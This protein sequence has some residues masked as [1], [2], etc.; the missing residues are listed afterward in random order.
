MGETRIEVALPLPVRSTFTYAVEGSQPLPG[1][2]VLVPF[3]QTERIGWVVGPG[4]PESPTRVRP[5]LDR[6]EAD[7]SVP[8]D[9]M[10]LAAWVADYYLAPLGMVL[11]TFLPSVLSDTGRDYLTY[12]GGKGQTLTPRQRKLMEA[13]EGSGHALRVRTLRRELG[14]GSLWPEIRA[15]VAGGVLGHEAIPPREPSVRTQKVVRLREW[16]SDLSARDELFGRARRQREAYETLESAGGAAELSHLVT[17]GGFSRSV[18]QGLEEK[19]VVVLEDSEVYRDP[20]LEDPPPD[21]PPLVPTPDQARV[22]SH[23]VEAL[24]APKPTPVLLHGV[25]GSGKTLVYIEL[26]KEVVREQGRGAIVLVPEIALTP[27][28]VSRF[29]AHFPDDLAVLHSGLSEGERFDAWRRL[30]NG[31]KRIAVGAR[32]AVFAPVQRLGVIVV[33]EEHDASYKQ[34]EGPRY[35]ARDVAVVRTRQTGG[36]CVLGSATPSLESWQ[37]GVLGKYRL[38]TLPQ[39]VGG[40]SL[41]PVRVVDLRT[42]RRREASG[43]RAGA[44]SGVL[45]DDLVEGIRVRLR[46]GE[47]VMLLLNRRGY[48][49]FVQCRECGEVW[50]CIRCSVSLT[51]HRLTGKLL[52]HHCRHEEPSPRRCDRC[53]STDLSFKGLGTEQ[54]ERVVAETFPDARIARMD[55]D[56]TSGK[57]SHHEILGRFGRGEVDILLG[58]QMISKGLDF[59]TVTLVGVVNADIGIH[60]PDFRAS[61]R[62]FQLLSQVAGRTGRGRLGGEVVVQTS[63]PDHFAVRA[64]LNHD[65]PAFA[66]RELAERASPSYPPHVRLANVLVSSP[67]L[68]EA[69]REA[70]AGAAWVRRAVGRA[71]Q[72]IEVVGPAPAPIEQLHGR[73]RWHFLVRSRGAA[74]LGRILE[75]FLD[76]HKPKGR[77]IR[78]VVD[79]DPVALL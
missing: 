29:R 36:L 61:E 2:R 19:G 33:D 48:S 57:W 21:P 72:R 47:Q 14:M 16:I 41:P 74:A 8:P 55:V 53:G 11:R 62:T 22:L 58:T 34:S 15:L 24:D 45:S 64:A 4:S 7:P 20:F 56:T 37:N 76:R 38:L 9:L 46:R 70:E 30:R 39:R 54:V 66:H 60:L 13:V 5:V 71:G 10:S 1:T 77:D 69:A 25:T 79:R 40:G 43:G 28:T 49:S 31:E 59:P 35:Q 50:R 27:Q 67:D 42:S 44:G 26:L 23:L 12:L 32:S 17:Q 51:F 75:S 6:L 18:I 63:L 65:F 78:V 3:R 73:W 52:C 68:E